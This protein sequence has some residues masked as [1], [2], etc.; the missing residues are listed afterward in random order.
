M[1]LGLP[2]CHLQHTW[3]ISQD[4]FTCYLKLPVANTHVLVSSFPVSSRALSPRFLWG[5]DLCKISVQVHWVPT[6]PPVRHQAPQ[7]Q[8]LTCCL[9]HLEYS[10]ALES[11]RSLSEVLTVLTFFPWPLVHFSHPY[12]LFPFCSESESLAVFEISPQDDSVTFE[13]GC[14]S[15]SGYGQNRDRSPFCPHLWSE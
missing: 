14:S 1:G 15:F 6:P 10:L 7:S 3:P 11:W 13:L 2:C 8:S 5:C 4:G 9:A 12:P